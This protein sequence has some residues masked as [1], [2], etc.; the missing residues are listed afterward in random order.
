MLNSLLH[1]Q[2]NFSSQKA[3]GA[4]M[5]AAGASNATD[6]SQQD[7]AVRLVVTGRTHWMR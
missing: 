7:E 4:G 5:Q 2:K 3:S 1:T 6:D